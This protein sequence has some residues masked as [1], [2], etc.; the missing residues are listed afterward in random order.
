[1]YAYLPSKTLQVRLHQSGGNPARLDLL[2][3]LLFQLDIQPIFGIELNQIKE[4]G[5]LILPTRAISRPFEDWEL[6]FVTWFIAQGNSLFHLSNEYPWTVND[7]ILGQRFGYQFQSR[8]I[9]LDSNNTFDIYPFPD[10]LNIFDPF[11]S[12][13]H[14]SVHHTSV[15][16]RGNDTFT[17]IANFRR[18][19][20]ANIGEMGS[21]GIA[22]PRDPTT[23]RGAIIALGDSGLLGRTILP[24]N[25]GPGLRAG[26]NYELVK[27]IMIW[28]KNQ[29]SLT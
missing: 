21:F 23:G 29:A 20:L 1:M 5:I 3:D 7:S 2:E 15:V 27:R 24:H 11:D 10:T 16:I 12:H 22:C 14:F 6:E 4:N 18:S 19:E 26:N 28:L 17:E 25:P 9:G 13:L 8:V